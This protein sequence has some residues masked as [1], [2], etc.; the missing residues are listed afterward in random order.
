M[1][2]LSSGRNCSARKPCADWWSSDW[3][4]LIA[5]RSIPLGPGLAAALAGA[6][7]RAERWVRSQAY[8]GL[9]VGCHSAADGPT[10]VHSA[11]ELRRS[12]AVGYARR[13]VRLSQ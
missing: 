10:V 4:R 12:H 6:V 11:K 7:D 2:A 13:L 8:Y 5:C 9:H 3:Y 1:R